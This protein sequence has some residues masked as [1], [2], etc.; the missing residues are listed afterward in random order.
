MRAFIL[1]LLG[2]GLLWLVLQNVGNT[3]A[4]EAATTAESGSLLPPESEDHGETPPATAPIPPSTAAADNSAPKPATIV[5]PAPTADAA[6]PADQ[7]AA[8]NAPAE[9]IALAAQLLHAPQALADFSR[10]HVRTLSSDRRDLAQA[11]AA[12]VL[13][14]ATEARR[15][16]RTLQDKPGISAGER[17]LLARALERGSDKPM[18]AAVEH[19]SPLAQ[20]ATMALLAKEGEAALQK[21]NTRDSARVFSD[22]LLE[23]IRAPWKADP[24]TLKAWS[25]ALQRAET[26]YQWN[27]S[28]DWPSVQVTVEK[29]DSLISIRKRV[30]KDNPELLVCTGLI[31]RA[32]EVRGGVVHP[33]QVLR[34]PTEKAHMLVSLSAHWTFFLLGDHVVAAWEVGI[35]KSGSETRP[36]TYTVGEKSTEPMWFRPGG[37]PVPYGDPENPLGTRWIAWKTPDG[38]SSGYGFHGTKEPDSIGQDLSEGCVRMLNRDVE[39]LYEI[40]PKDAAILVQA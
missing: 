33:G 31:E 8:V 1:L 22:L 26:G 28:G 25:Q 10:E 14:D 36:G 37:K 6:R 32:N 15:L 3:R 30:L 34:I 39:E 23:E 11:F 16:E 27:R 24:A 4:G 20:A 13:D 12:L 19:E 29:G 9:E 21:G 17:E 35:G 2:G 5:E 18:M 38:A 40:L 7:A